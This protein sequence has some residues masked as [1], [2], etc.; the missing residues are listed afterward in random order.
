MNAW[1]HLPNAR[2]ID[3]VIESLKYHPEVWNA[4]RN[5]VRDTAWDAAH[6][7]TIQIAAWSAAQDADYNSAPREAARCAAWDVMTWQTRERLIEA[8]QEGARTAAWYVIVALIA[9]DDAEKYLG[10]TTD[11]LKTWAILSE[12]PGAIL[13]LPMVYVK[14][15]EHVV[16]S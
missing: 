4:A 11:Q 14:E 9:Y 13:M 15:Q 8:A 2:H 6:Y 12:E 10:M 7:S 1:S 5:A 16:L 3:W